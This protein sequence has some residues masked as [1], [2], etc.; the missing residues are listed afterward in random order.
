MKSSRTNSR[1][2]GLAGFNSSNGSRIARGALAAAAL[3]LIAGACGSTSSSSSSSS[4]TAAAATSTTAAVPQVTTSSLD[5]TFAAMSSLK[6]LVSQG[7]GKVAVILPDT[8]SSARYVAFDAPYL[9]KA[10]AD[11]GYSSSN[12]IIENA[13]G[14]DATQ[15]SDAQAAITNGASV[16]AVDPIDSGVGA[17]I[18]SYAAAHGVKVIDYD[19]ITLKGSASYYVSFN[20]V[21]VGKL[22]GQSFLSCVTAW[23]VKNPQV[24]ILDGSPTDNNATLFAQGYNS[25]LAPA[26]ASGKLTKVGEQAVTNWDNQVALTDFQQAYTA[27]PNINAV[28]TANDGLGNAVVSALKTLNVKPFTVPTTGQD[29][30]LQGMTNILQGYQCSSIYKPIYLEAQA[31]VALA[32]YLRAGITPPSGL[33]NGTTNNQTT[34]VPSVLLTPITVTASNMASTVIKDGFIQKSAL[35]VG[36]VAALCTKNGI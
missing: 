27:H 22:I 17:S 1:L 3:A 7:K 32:T 34:N 11:A 20:N 36:T 8:Q 18:E 6:P 9:A 13:Q 10:F 15:L 30:T 33:V 31:T 21:Q 35:C 24:Y 26:F 19:R 14:S 2:K 5:S 23:N 16:L 12:Y 29:A 4:T 25:V 28:V